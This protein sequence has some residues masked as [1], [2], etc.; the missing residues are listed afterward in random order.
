MKEDDIPDED[1]FK[2]YKKELPKRRKREERKR[3]SDMVN[4]TSGSKNP[5]ML[6]YIG[7][8]NR[9]EFLMRSTFMAKEYE[10]TCMYILRKRDNC[11]YGC[12]NRMRLG[13]FFVK[14]DRKDEVLREMKLVNPQRYRRIKSGPTQEELL[15]K[16]TSF[17]KGEMELKS[18]T[19]GKEDVFAFKTPSASKVKKG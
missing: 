16:K 19:P 15:R 10:Y 7:R 14:K 18:K 6:C 5:N 2:E 1:L 4:H 17:W 3:F 13:F 8:D 12:K 9:E 11:L